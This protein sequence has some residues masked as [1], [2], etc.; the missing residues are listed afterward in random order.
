MHQAILLCHY[1]ASL[2]KLADFGHEQQEELLQR[3]KQLQQAH[4]DLAHNS[5]SILAAQV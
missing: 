1:R 2:Q 4:D 5:K 3:Q